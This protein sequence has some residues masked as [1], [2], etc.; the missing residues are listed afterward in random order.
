MNK[1]ML[2]A[3]GMSIAATAPALADS[4]VKPTKEIVPIKMTCEE[5]LAV[6]E[7]AR[8]QIVYWSEGYSKKGELEDTTIDIDRTNRLVPAL[9][10]DCKLEPHSSYWAKM[11]KRFAMN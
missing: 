2:W 9:V 5:F 7:L 8:P 4:P 3:I 6:D 11:K 10:N 1:L